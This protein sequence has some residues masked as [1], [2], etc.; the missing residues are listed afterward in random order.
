[1]IFYTSVHKKHKRK[2]NAAS[3][4]ILI[5]TPTL[6]AQPDVKIKF[7]YP[8]G[9]EI[10]SAV[11][12]FRLFRF[13]S[14]MGALIKTRERNKKF[15]LIRYFPKNFP[16]KEYLSAKIKFSLIDRKVPFPTPHAT[17]LPCA[18]IQGEICRL[19]SARL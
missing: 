8:N 19:G 14:L 15:W 3:G 4:S 17:G 12:L 13:L 2:I 7:D 10:F 6:R 16:A 5:T 1:M 11:G 9:V 18:S